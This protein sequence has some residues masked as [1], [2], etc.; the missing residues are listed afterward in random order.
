MLRLLYPRRRG[1]AYST[2]CCLRAVGSISFEEGPQETEKCCLCQA[3][4][5]WSDSR[6]ST[7][8]SDGASGYKAHF[9][10]ENDPDE[11]DN[12]VEVTIDRANSVEPAN[13][14]SAGNAVADDPPHLLHGSKALAAITAD[15][16]EI[17]GPSE[18]SYDIET[19]R[20][21]DERRKR[22]M[23]DRCISLEDLKRFSRKY[24]LHTPVPKDLDSL[25]SKDT[26]RQQ[27]RDLVEDAQLR[28]PGPSAPN[29]IASMASTISQVSA[30][31]RQQNLETEERDN[32]LLTKLHILKLIDEDVICHL[33]GVHKEDLFGFVQSALRERVH[34]S[35]GKRFFH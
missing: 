19:R 34:H 4:Q 27:S 7:A 12:K 21:A 9:A 18:V 3:H 32:H 28:A 17:L 8:P 6:C 26:A 25:R 16:T 14:L 1:R 10:I 13:S 20:T 11:K 30:D 29:V 5:P 23:Y 22:S 31:L 15:K 2:I 24:R 33:K 35:V